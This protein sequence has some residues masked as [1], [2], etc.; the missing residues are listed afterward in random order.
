[1]FE[2]FFVVLADSLGCGGL[3]RPL[4]QCSPV[5]KR[6]QATALQRVTFAWIHLTLVVKL[7][8]LTEEDP[9][10]ITGS[11]GALALLVRRAWS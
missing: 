4:R 8:R 3:A 2:K 11:K 9:Q 10:P 7:C 1:M 6:W 5:T